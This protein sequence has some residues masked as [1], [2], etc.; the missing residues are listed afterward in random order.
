MDVPSLVTNRK[1]YYPQVVQ[2]PM[3]HESDAD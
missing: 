2:I 3:P 1:I